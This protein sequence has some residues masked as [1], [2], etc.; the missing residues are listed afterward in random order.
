MGKKQQL[1]SSIALTVQNIFYWAAK[2]AL[3]VSSIA[4]NELETR[5]VML[6]KVGLVGR[7]ILDD[8]DKTGRYST[9]SIPTAGSQ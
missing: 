2:N 4:E 9:V 7:G 6:R 1:L 8:S 5:G 3:D